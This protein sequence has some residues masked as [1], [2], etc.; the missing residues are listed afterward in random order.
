MK[1]LFRPFIAL[2]CAV[3]DQKKK[4]DGEKRVW[5]GEVGFRANETLC[6]IKLFCHF[7]SSIVARCHHTCNSGMAVHVWDWSFLHLRVCEC[8]CVGVWVGSGRVHVLYMCVMKTKWWGVW[9]H[10]FAP[11]SLIRQP[12]GVW[13]ECRPGA[14]SSELLHKSVLPREK[15]GYMWTPLT[16]RLSRTP[17]SR[18][19]FFFGGGF[20]CF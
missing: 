16:S 8:A 14:Y 4:L 2:C 20:G 15:P 1:K 13:C 10:G 17:F 3:K 9:V 6:Y 11:P 18:S 7:H 12:P 19:R 5:R